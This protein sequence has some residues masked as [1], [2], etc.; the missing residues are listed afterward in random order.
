MQR[1]LSLLLATILLLF[2]LISCGEAATPGGISPQGTDAA[3]ESPAGP[4][5][6]PA[7][8]PV[9]EPDTDLFAGSDPLPADLSV[10]AN[11]KTGDGSVLGTIVVPAGAEDLLAYAGQELAYH[12]KKVTGSDLPVVSRT[13][14]GY[15]SFIIATPDSLPAVSEMFSDDLSWLADLGTKETGKWAPDGFAIRLV[16][17][18][19]WILGNTARGA[20]NGVYDLIEDN[21]GVLWVRA[22][23]SK[24]LIFREM[25]EATISRVDYREKS[26]FLMRGWLLCGVTG[27][28]TNQILFSRNKLNAMNADPGHGMDYAGFG[29]TIKWLLTSSPAYDPNET[30]Y[31]ETDDEGNSLGLE[32]SHQ[33]NPWSEK[34]AEVIAA[35]IINQMQNSSKRFIFIGEEDAALHLRCVPYDTE[36]FEYAPGQFVQPDAENYYST[37][38]CTMINKIAR[39]VREAVPDGEV[40]AFA[41]N[42]AIVPPECEME[43][44][45]QICYAAWAEDLSLPILSQKAKDKKGD[46]MASNHCDWVRGWGE[47]SSHLYF[48]NYYICYESCT[49][50]GWP[51]WYRIQQDLQDYAAMGVDGLI[52]EGEIDLETDCGLLDYWDEPG[53]HSN[54]WDQNMMLYWLYSKLAW[55]P[56]EDIPTL[57]AYFCDSVYGDASPYMQEYYS[58]L[59]KGWNDGTAEYKRIVNIHTAPTECYKN[60]VRKQGIGKDLLAALENAYNAAS[61][62]VKDSILYVWETAKRQLSSFGSY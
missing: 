44:N 38:M 40:G 36:P 19:V 37:V 53:N 32:G 7:T 8:E 26:P 14:E 6:Q 46:Y 27:E 54:V 34:A 10:P 18:N 5:S 35:N 50:Y 11:I 30:E 29:H 1:F 23:E 13:G 58:L 17:G 24:G 15:G 52:P 39:M 16:G 57:I 55:N 28:P 59:E 20:L 45:V 60:F 2:A 33:V 4:A 62:P 25:P 41:Y 61:G 42:N 22:D 9:T 56:W 48:W 12:V 43:D 21:L 49:Q 3:S 47:K 51:I 31:W